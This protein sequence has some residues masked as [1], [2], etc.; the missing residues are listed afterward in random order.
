MISLFSGEELSGWKK[1]KE[2]VVSFV[3]SMYNFVV[4]KDK[5]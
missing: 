2:D 4:E 1:N 5:K 3:L